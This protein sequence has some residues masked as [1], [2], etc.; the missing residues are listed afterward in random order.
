MRYKVFGEHTGLRVSELILGTGNFGTRWGY[1]APPDE[2]RRILDGYLDA[3]GNFLDTTDSYQFGESET[4]LGSFIRSN[5]DDV[6]LGTKYTQSADPNGSLSV[7]G[8]SRKA[9]VRSLD[10]SLKRLR[11]DRIDFYWVHLPDGDT[12]IDEIVRGLDGLVRAGKILY[13]G[14]SDFP[15][16]RLAGAATLAAIRGFAPI[17]AQQIEY[18]LVQRTADR[19]LLPM[20]AAYGIA[21]AVWSPFGGGVLTGKYRRGATG[22]KTGFGGRLFHPED[23]EQKTAILD[24]VELIANETGSSQGRVAL[25]WT[26]AKGVFPIIGPKTRAQLDDNL[27]ST[28]VSL[29][30]E[31]IRRLDEASAVPLGF[32][33]EMLAN[34]AYQDRMAGGKR[35]LLDRTSRA[36]R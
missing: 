2:A 1:G 18:S 6:V 7:T 23:T 34:P 13:V 25:A 15:A 26:R 24:T 27:A 28:A 4:L 17:A 21:T 32:P 14:L 35:A 31:Q 10:E 22:R 30:V 12:P 9:M 16:W 11:T 19:E 20:A 5:R 29:S 36:V 8:N 33:H 3:G